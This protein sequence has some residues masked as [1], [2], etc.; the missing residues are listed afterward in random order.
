MK[1]HPLSSGQGLTD[2]LLDLFS[3]EPLEGAEYLPFVFQIPVFQM[4]SK[5]FE[6]DDISDI[7][8]SDNDSLAS[9]ISQPVKNYYWKTVSFTVFQFSEPAFWFLLLEKGLALGVK[10]PMREVVNII[11]PPVS[12]FSYLNI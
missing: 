9:V 12:V 1:S 7:V 10:S 3:S 4:L 2:L 6:R 11:I 8:L 5:F